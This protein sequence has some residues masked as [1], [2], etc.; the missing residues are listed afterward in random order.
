MLPDECE[1][2]R[3]YELH[4]VDPT[5]N[6]AMIP[7]YYAYKEFIVGDAVDKVP[8][9]KL[10]SAS[11]DPENIVDGEPT[12][13]VFHVS[14]SGYRYAGDMSFTVSHD[15]EVV[16]TS[17]KQSVD[18]DRDD[19]ADVEFTETFDLPTASDYVFTLNDSSK[20]VGKVENVAIT[21]DEPKLSLTDETAVPE[22]IE[23]NTDTELKFCVRNDGYLY[24]DDVACQLVDDQNNVILTT[25][26]Q[27]LNVKRNEEQTLTFTVNIN[28]PVGTACKAVLLDADNKAIGERSFE[29]GGVYDGIRSLLGNAD[30]VRVAVYNANG[31]LVSTQLDIDSLP[32]GI[33]VIHVVT[34]HGEKNIKLIK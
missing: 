10:E 26:K 33:Y 7:S 1:V 32:Q 21:A 34:R 9:L 22:T 3:T 28:V 24:N 16:F 31:R 27:N 29:V 30:V 11:F 2:G 20:E 12:T 23:N 13:V 4:I 8:N 14:N 17:E 5:T 25:E 15:G 18:I 6:E 19:E